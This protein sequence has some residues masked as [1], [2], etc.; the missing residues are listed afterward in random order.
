MWQN[1]F[2]EDDI[3][4]VETCRSLIIHILIICSIMCAILG[5]I[6]NNKECTVHESKWILWSSPLK[7]YYHFSQQK[8]VQTPSVFFFQNLDTSEFETRPYHPYRRDSSVGKATELRTGRSGDRI[9][10]GARFSAP[11]QTGPVAHPASCT[12][13]TGSLP[14]VKRPGS[15]ADLTNPIFSAEVSNRVELHFYPP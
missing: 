15:G 11:V 3:L 9:P 6:I 12:M 2:P 13:G 14:G 1:K 5:W 7:F 10:V 4:N 8:L